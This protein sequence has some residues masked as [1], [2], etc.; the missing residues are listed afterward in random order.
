MAVSETV[1]DLTLEANSQA[2]RTNGE[3]DSEQL[4]MFEQLETNQETPKEMTT[5]AGEAARKQNKQRKRSQGQ[6]EE[7]ATI[8]CIT[9]YLTRQTDRQTDTE[10]DPPLVTTTSASKEGEELEN[11]ADGK[12]SSLNRRHRATRRMENTAPTAIRGGTGRHHHP[13]E[14]SNS[15]TSTAGTGRRR[16]RGIGGRDH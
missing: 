7:E 5:Q 14:V 13:D 12:D 1:V 11:R 3:T 6:K 15:N 8:K 16:T 4:A 2:K 10:P 9:A